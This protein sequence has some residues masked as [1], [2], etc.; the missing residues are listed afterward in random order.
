MLRALKR[1]LNLNAS[2]VPY[3]APMQKTKTFNVFLCSGRVE[4]SHHAADFTLASIA[5][6]AMSFAVVIKKVETYL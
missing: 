1:T 6:L 2:Q 5:S 3:A 4:K